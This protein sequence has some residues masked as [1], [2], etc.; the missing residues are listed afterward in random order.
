MEANRNQYKL[1]AAPMAS[2]GDYEGNIPVKTNAGNKPSATRDDIQ[3]L[4]RWVTEI[5]S[6]SERMKQQV[7][8]CCAATPGPRPGPPGPRPGPPGPAGAK[9]FYDERLHKCEQMVPGSGVIPL[10]GNG[11]YESST[12]CQF[13][14]GNQANVL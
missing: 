10:K 6:E 12:M 8:K 2:F 7:Q 5:Q 9:F 13:V 3:H 1:A 14:H 4:A 11:P